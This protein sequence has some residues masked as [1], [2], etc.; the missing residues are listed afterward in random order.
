MTSNMPCLEVAVSTAKESDTFER[1][2]RQAH[3]DLVTL[4]G[5]VS[6]IMLRE[7]ENEATHADLILWESAADAHSAAELIQRDERFSS[8]MESIAS[9]TH[10]AHYSGASLEA[11]NRLVE[12]PIVEIAAYETS[13]SNIAGLRSQIYDALRVI[14]GA[15]PEVAGTSI[16]DASM[17]LDLIGWDNKTIHA[18][19]SNMLPSQHPELEPFFSNVGK[20]EIRS[21]F[22]VM[23]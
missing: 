6:D 17:L 21:L 15:S 3:L 8:F 20:M 23:K 14:E 4:P 10:F 9:V 16:S 2:Q 12:S 1:L 11:M 5:F 22:E 18:A 13:S 19:A 7:L